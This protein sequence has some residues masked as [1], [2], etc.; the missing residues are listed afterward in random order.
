M[1]SE[2]ARGMVVYSKAAILAAVAEAAKTL[3]YSKFKESTKLL[4]SNFLIGKM[5][6]I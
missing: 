1:T 6:P 5:C 3:G 2:K 4:T